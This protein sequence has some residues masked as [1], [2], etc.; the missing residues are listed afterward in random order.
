MIPIVLEGGPFCGHEAEVEFRPGK[1]WIF[2]MRTPDGALEAWSYK[3]AD[4]SAAGGSRWVL[5]VDVFV[6]RG[7]AECRVPSEK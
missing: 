4:R 7:S 5:A 1:R 3:W 6:G 2:A